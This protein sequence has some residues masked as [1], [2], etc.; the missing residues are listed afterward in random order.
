[1]I[2]DFDVLVVGDANPDLILRGDVVPRFGQSEQLLD[3]ADFLPGGS[4]AIVA[5]GLSR[6]GLRTAMVAVVGADAFGALTRE[7][8]VTAGVDVSHLQTHPEQPTGLT[9]ILTRPDQLTGPFEPDGR[10]MLTLVGSI[11]S[12][13][14]ATIGDDL[15]RR[16]RHLHASSFYLQ[17]GLATGLADLFERA[18]SAGASTSLDT[19]LDPAGQWNGLEEV[20]GVTDILLPNRTEILGIAGRYAGAPVQVGFTDPA[21]AARVIAKYGPLVVVKDGELGAIA[22]TGLNSTDSTDVLREPGYPVDVVDSTG[23]GDSFDAAFIAG[24][25]QGLPLAKCLTMACRAGALSTL[26]VGGTSSQITAEELAELA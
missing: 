16:T 6:L 4:G 25:L 26:G 1:M 2:R 17:P 20:L 10:T 7:Q 12:L 3:S 5:H 11:G 9:V 19:N 13:D 18:H 23:A 24:H 14:P 8:L 22:V 15:L 21:D